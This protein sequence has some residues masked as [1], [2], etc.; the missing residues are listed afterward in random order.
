[1]IENLSL[2]SEWRVRKAAAHIAIEVDGQVMLMSESQGRYFGLDDIGSDIWKR[3]E[4]P[5]TM[6]QLSASLAGDY[7]AAPG[8]IEHD[9]AAMVTT[10][11]GYGLVEV[12]S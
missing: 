9:V 10:L 12:E 8:V 3:L 7:T 2:N 6:T 5:Q 1:M 11:H 4:K